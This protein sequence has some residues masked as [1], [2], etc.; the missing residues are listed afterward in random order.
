MDIPDANIQILIDR[1]DVDGD[2]EIDLT[3]FFS[4]IE[5]EQK[6]FADNTTATSESAAVSG[7]SKALLLPA[8][9]TT[10]ASHHPR[11][12][13]GGRSERPKSAPVHRPRGRDNH[14]VTAP[15]RLQAAHPHHSQSHYEEEAEHEVE[16]E[17]KEQLDDLDYTRVKH[18]QTIATRS[19]EPLPSSSQPHAQVT[20]GEEVDVMWMSRMLQ[21]QAEIEGRLGNR[22]YRNNNQH[23]DSIQ[24]K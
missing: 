9:R 16:E 19:Q 18:G 10:A 4:F 21:A 7:Q 11:G 13:S 15:Y 6:N 24:L 8:P 12:G 17:D 2:G 20:A 5:S 22:Y 3:E 14:N 1:F 23:S